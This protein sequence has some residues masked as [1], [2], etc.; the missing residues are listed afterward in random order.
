MADKED[1]RIKSTKTWIKWNN[2]EDGTL[3]KYG[4][5]LFTKPEQCEQLKIELKRRMKNNDAAKRKRSE[6]TA[7]KKSQVKYDDAIGKV[8]TNDSWI[9]WTKL[10]PGETMKYKGR[11]F[12]KDVPND[13]E[14]LMTRIINSMNSYAKKKDQTNE[15][16]A[17]DTLVVM[18]SGKRGKTSNDKEE[19]V[20]DEIDDDKIVRQ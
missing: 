12:H 16:K 19:L 9:K 20:Y 10:K 3:M 4:N 8:N 2:L 14:K 17:A 5:K 11:E 6:H 1:N 7:P 15:K 18:M 13:Q